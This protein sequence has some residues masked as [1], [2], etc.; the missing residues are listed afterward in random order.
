MEEAAKE[1]PADIECHPSLTYALDYTVE[2]TTSLT[3]IIILPEHRVRAEGWGFF[4]TVDPHWLLAG[5]GE[6]R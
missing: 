3:W 5:E 2:R 6:A 1:L 4:E